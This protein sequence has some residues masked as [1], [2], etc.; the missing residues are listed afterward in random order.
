MRVKERCAL[1][2]RYVV[3]IFLL[4]M[5]CTRCEAQFSLYDSLSSNSAENEIY[6]AKKFNGIT[7][8]L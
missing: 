4:S 2:N 7:Q 8:P 1:G 5:G 6:P 3:E